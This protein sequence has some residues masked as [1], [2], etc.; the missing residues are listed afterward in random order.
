MKIT[1]TAGHSTEAPGAVYAGY[2]EADLAAELCRKCVAELSVRGHTV[3]T[4]TKGISNLPL[5]EA[6]QLILGSELAIEFHF[7]AAADGSVGGTEIISLPS[8]KTKAQAIAQAASAA[9]G[10]KLR[11][12]KGWMRQE[13]SA[14]GKLAYVNAGGMILEVMF[15]SSANDRAL[16]F[17][18]LPGLVKALCD[19]IEKL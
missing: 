4:D 19:T 14:H 15:M 16:Y 2:K 13:D 9:L 8:Q 11:R 17:S 1:L 12:D 6:L 18:N 5:K 10:T 3:K 7:N